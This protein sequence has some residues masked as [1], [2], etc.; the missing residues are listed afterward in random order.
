MRDCVRATYSKEP[1]FEGDKRFD[2]AAHQPMPEIR[3]AVMK[4]GCFVGPL[5]N[6][7]YS[8]VC[9]V[10]T[11]AAGIENA[12][13]SEGMGNHSADF[14]LMSLR[15]CCSSLRVSSRMICIAVS[16]GE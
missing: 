7:N 5:R 13:Y 11:K 1:G 12:Y 14:I 8:K 4:A 3:C 9:R 16:V 6:N 15:R 10:R 2:A